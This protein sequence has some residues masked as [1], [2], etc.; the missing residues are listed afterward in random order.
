MRKSDRS[1]CG[2]SYYLELSRAIR[3]LYAEYTDRVES[4]G[5]DEC[6]LDVTESLSLFRRTF[7]ARRPGGRIFGRQRDCGRYPR[8]RQGEIRAHRE[9]GGGGQ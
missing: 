6:W 9:R 8:P 3:A 2:F 4:F 7:G 5:I 1:D